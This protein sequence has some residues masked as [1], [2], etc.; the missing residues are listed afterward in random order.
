MKLN[1]LLIEIAVALSRQGYFN[2]L[3][4]VMEVDTDRLMRT[5][6][7]SPAKFNAIMTIRREMEELREEVEHEEVHSE[8]KM[9]HY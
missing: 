4:R 5:Y 3:Y 6:A 8:N 9:I 1:L 7:S 2:Q